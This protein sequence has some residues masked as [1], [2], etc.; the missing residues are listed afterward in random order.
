MERIKP[1]VR[2]TGEDGNAFAILGKVKKALEDNCYTREE[3]EDFLGQAIS[4]DYDNL[5]QVCMF[6]VNVEEIP[7][8]GSPKLSRIQMCCWRA[9]HP[10]QAHN[11]TAAASSET[12]LRSLRM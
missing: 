1:T 8:E 2:L 6:W 11:T 10:G 4:S 5:L 3:I 9:G 7:E 12:D